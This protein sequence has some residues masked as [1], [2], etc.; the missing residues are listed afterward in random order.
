ML[1]TMTGT[2]TGLLVVVPSPS[3]P[4]PLKPQVNTLAVSQPA[5]LW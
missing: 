5:M 2:G 3:W 4:Y 1:K